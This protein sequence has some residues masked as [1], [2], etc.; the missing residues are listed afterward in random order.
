MA[1]PRG[2]GI[3]GGMERDYRKLRVWQEGHEL[4]LLVWRLTGRFPSSE[5]VLADQLRK[6]AL[7]VPSN[8]VEGC[9]RHSLRVFLNHVSIASGSAAELE[10]QLFFAAELG[11]IPDE[12]VRDCGQ[13][14]ERLRR[15]IAALHA[16]LGRSAA[17]RRRPRKRSNR[18]PEAPTRSATP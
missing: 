1:V 3:L 12:A 15:G 18:G 8:L 7:S 11:L 17:G 2:G 5:R 10:Y 9:G 16:A 6:S 4:A 14:I 13:R